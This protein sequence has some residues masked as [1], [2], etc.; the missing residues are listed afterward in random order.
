M[1]WNVLGGLTGG[2]VVEHYMGIDPGKDGGI[3]IIDGDG[4]IRLCKPM[5][6]LAG[7]IVD[8]KEIREMVKWT[9]PRLIALEHVNA[10]HKASAKSS[11]AFGR[12]FGTLESILIC[13][14]ARWKYVRPKLWQKDFY[15]GLG[16]GLTTKE[17]SLIVAKQTYPDQI[18]TAT[19][20]SRKAHDGMTDS[21][22]IAEWARR[23]EQLSK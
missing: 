21:A 1:E 2:D 3:T 6:M 8:A 17:K 5:P 9:A 14:T 18:W 16:K 22:L 23:H 7:D 4:R 13:G 10:F 12:N 11:F 15:N 20:R 19:A